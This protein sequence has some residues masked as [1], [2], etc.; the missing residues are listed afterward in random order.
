[1]PSPQYPSAEKPWPTSPCVYLLADEETGVVKFGTTIRFR[2]R[3]RQING[4]NVC[5][6]G[7]R[8]HHYSLVAFVELPSAGEARVLERRVLRTAPFPKCCGPEEFLGERDAA[9]YFLT[10]SV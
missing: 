9:L 3:L 7:R 10:R 8:R 2:D 1:M 6:D 4:Q 5:R